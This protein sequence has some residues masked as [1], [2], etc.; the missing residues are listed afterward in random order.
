MTS[1]IFQFLNVQD[2]IHCEDEHGVPA[3]RDKKTGLPLP[4]LSRSECKALSNGVHLYVFLNSVS[5]THFDLDQILTKERCENNWALKLTNLRKL[6]RN[7]E[8]CYV[9]E[10]G[11]DFDLC[12]GNKS[13]LKI[14]DLTSIAKYSA[15]SLEDSL[16]ESCNTALSQLF[17]FVSALA[18]QCKDRDRFVERIM[19]MDQDSQLTMK[20]FIEFSLAS[21]GP[22]V[23]KGNCSGSESSHV[24]GSSE[25]RSSP[26][27]NCSFD[28]SS[29][30]NLNTPVKT[31]FI[32]EHSNSNA[33]QSLKDVTSGP[34]F[35]SEQS[36][37]P[38]CAKVPASPSQI[39]EKLKALHQ[40]EIERL[41]KELELKSVLVKERED[42]LDRVHKLLSEKEKDLQEKTNML[43]DEVSISQA[44]A[45]KLRK[46]EELIHAYQEKLEHAGILNDQYQLLEVKSTS[47]TEKIKKLEDATKS[48]PE[49]Q[50]KIADK[51]DQIARL[52]SK[53]E[54]ATIS[55]KN[56][57]KQILTLEEALSD[58]CSQNEAAK[59][60]LETTREMLEIQKLCAETKSSDASTPEKVR[61]LFS[62]LLSLYTDVLSILC[63]LSRKWLQS[64][65]IW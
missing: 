31:S 4:H 23:Y 8:L 14:I 64:R 60:E 54:E 29:F 65:K 30:L 26:S 46:S 15:P 53:L 48:M 7:L 6:V 59:V 51:N 36:P 35:H 61:P 18:V 33:V 56:K 28:S 38:F 57:S 62:C 55:C 43:A 50:H 42:A 22:F 5:P 52:I 27:V 2:E 16:Y 41:N 21:L 24:R 34:T 32:Q 17:G 13:V 20:D 63:V 1:T 37:I 47:M 10:L 40:N 11:V 58:S 19:Q 9:D 45:L 12:E 49:M 44:Q 39:I 25:V 3:Y